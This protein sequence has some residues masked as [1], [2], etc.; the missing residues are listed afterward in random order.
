MSA[1]AQVALLRQ[2]EQIARE[3]S[4]QHNADARLPLAQRHPVS[5]LLAVR[6]WEP[7]LFKTFRRSE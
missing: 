2:V 6:P 7:A 3:Y 4:E 1:E 5:V